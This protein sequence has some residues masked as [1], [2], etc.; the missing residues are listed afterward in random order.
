MQQSSSF[1]SR[2]QAHPVRRALFQIHLWLGITIGLYLTVIC[3]SGSLLVFRSDMQRAAFPELLASS[4]TGAPADIVDVLAALEATYPGQRVSGIDAPTVYRQTY[5]AYVAEG[6]RFHTILS[7]PADGHVL[8]ELPPESWIGSLQSLHFNLLLGRTGRLLNQIAALCLLGLLLSGA[9]I[10]WQGRHWKRGFSLRKGP[11]PG[12]LRNFHGATGIWL[13]AVLLMVTIT[14]SSLMFPSQFRTLVDALTPAM[15]AESATRHSD[16]RAGTLSAAQIIRAARTLYPS[17]YISRVVLPTDSD[18]TYQINFARRSPTP[19]A[20]SA[21][22]TRY[23]N[24][25]TGT[26]VDAHRSPG[27]T[28]Q[29]IAWMDAMHVGNFAGN[30]TRI[31]WSLLGLVPPLLFVTGAVLWWRRVVR[32]AI[33]R[34]H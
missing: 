19:L 5:L 26:Q 12:L 11:W 28:D 30:G 6:D 2:P 16:A 10:W 4:H 25:A 8:G 34:G 22:G 29:V 15:R 14:A 9:V 1:M 23:F 32:P 7:D 31:L 27:V 13:W 33:S 20:P 21:Q 17:E 3:L 24:G 18:P